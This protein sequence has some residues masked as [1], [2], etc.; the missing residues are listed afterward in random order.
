MFVRAFLAEKLSIASGAEPHGDSGKCISN[1][2]CSSKS[3]DCVR[4]ECVAGACR[5]S[6]AQYHIAMDIG[7]VR[8]ETPGIF[9]IVD[10]DQPLWA[11]P[12]W[13]SIAMLTYL[14][15]GS[16]I[17]WVET[18]NVCD[19][20]LSQTNALLLSMCLFSPPQVCGSHPG[21]HLYLVVHR[22]VLDCSFFSSE[23][24]DAVKSGF[25]VMLQLRETLAGADPV[26]T[27]PVQSQRTDWSFM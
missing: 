15:P 24:K 21:M 2:D 18:I 25:Y 8:Q 3:C 20:I 1:A 26:F 9:R 13:D 6:W 23:E 14:D 22:R 12:I 4:M 10:E 16:S 11:E 27:K 17:G 5:C 19:N 7:L